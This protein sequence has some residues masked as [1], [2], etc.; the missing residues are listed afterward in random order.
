LFPVRNL[1]QIGTVDP[2]VPIKILNRMAVLFFDKY[3][4]K[5]SNIDLGKVCEE[6]DVEFVSKVHK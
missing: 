6:F 4:R 2:V 5:M 1:S 3:I